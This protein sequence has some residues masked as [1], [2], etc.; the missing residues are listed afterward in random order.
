MTLAVTQNSSALLHYKLNSFV[1]SRLRESMASVDVTL[2]SEPGVG[3]MP[4]H[5]LRMLGQH[6]ANYNMQDT[7]FAQLLYNL[8]TA[9]TNALVSRV[10]TTLVH[11]LQVL[12]Q[13]CTNDCAEDHHSYYA[14][15][16]PVL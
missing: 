10:G 2:P 13:C 16:L 11:H 5:H 3:T 14:I 7:V 4:V 9:Y 12:A 15:M 8:N 6:R 1:D